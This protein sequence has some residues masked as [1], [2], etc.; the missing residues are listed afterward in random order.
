LR[1]VKIAGEGRNVFISATTLETVQCVRLHSAYVDYGK[2]ECLAH[3]ETLLELTQ[4]LLPE[5]IELSYSASTN[6]L[7]VVQRRNA[8]NIK[9]VPITDFP[10]I[11]L[12][13][14]TQDVKLAY[15]STP[16]DLK[17]AAA[18]VCAYCQSPSK[19]NHGSR[20]TEFLRI[21][22][23]PEHQCIRLIGSDGYSLSSVAV[24][25]A[26]SVTNEQIYFVEPST[27]KAAVAALENDD[28]EHR[29]LNKNGGLAIEIYLTHQG[30]L[31]LQ[32]SVRTIF[33]TP[34][35]VLQF[36]PP[37][38][39]SILTM[40]LS[41]Y[42]SLISVLKAS[43]RA[44]GLLL[45][46]ERDTHDTMFITFSDV[47]RTVRVM[48]NAPIESH[49]S[50]EQFTVF[51]N[52]RLN[53]SLNNNVAE[54]EKSLVYRKETKTQ[55][56]DINLQL[57]LDE[58]GEIVVGVQGNNSIDVFSTALEQDEVGKRWMTYAA[59]L[60]VKRTYLQALEVFKSTVPTELAEKPWWELPAEEVD[61]RKARTA[62]DHAEQAVSGFCARNP[63][64]MTD[65]LK[66]AGGENT[67]RYAKSHSANH[68][69]FR[70][71]NSDDCIASVPE[72]SPNSEVGQTASIRAG[73]NAST[74]EAL[75]EP[76]IPAITTS[77]FI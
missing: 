25:A 66:S 24:M 26:V 19:N 35:K 57:T 12:L 8:A 21:E 42:S 49:Y 23:Q 53:L 36:T 45:A 41:D 9:S 43:K 59:M 58:K 20:A 27:F 47:E 67:G 29:R 50:S 33:L 56:A 62:L 6:L 64:W 75:E 77:A 34:E 46:L 72:Q 22:F 10:E 18:H 1:F 38:F 37:R 52:L 32:N 48:V 68:P 31:A 4:L 16:Q 60:R 40:K 2:F 65:E 54:F 5:R 74:C 76:T 14:P 63:F 73:A 61:W 11:P 13:N 44:G 71:G 28:K 3:Y 39:K 69:V 70:H 7:S 51:P 55:E 17:N 30:V 15:I